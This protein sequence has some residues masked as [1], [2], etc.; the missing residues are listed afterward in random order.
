[1]NVDGDTATGRAYIH[2]FGRFPGDKSHE[3]Y[4]RYHDEYRR[5][6][7]GWR[8]ASRVYEI[9][10]HDESPLLGS[11]GPVNIVEKDSYVNIIVGES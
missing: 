1:I 10:Y 2:E 3:N 8:F 4:S 9:I 6:P 7:D 5:T 11:T